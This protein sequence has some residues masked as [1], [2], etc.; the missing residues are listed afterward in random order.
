VFF[1]NKTDVYNESKNTF[2]KNACVFFLTP[3]HFV[4]Q[5]N[6][7]YEEFVINN[8]VGYRRVFASQGTEYWHNFPALFERIDKCLFKDYG[9]TIKSYLLLYK[10]SHSYNL[11][12]VPKPTPNFTI[13]PP[14]FLRFFDQHLKEVSMRE[15]KCNF[16]SAINHLPRCEPHA[17]LSSFYR[18]NAIF[19]SKHVF[20]PVSDFNTVPYK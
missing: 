7:A 13:K 17:V 6:D 19:I 16:A 18:T 12:Y 4:N 2:P 9:N 14:H 15:I 1:A 8:K 3:N 5:T 11:K 20:H 10:I